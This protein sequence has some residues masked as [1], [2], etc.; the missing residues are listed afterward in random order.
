MDLINDLRKMNFTESE[1]KVYT[2]LLRYGSS[3]G[4]E[5]SKY[6]GVARSKIYNHIENLLA[7][8]VLEASNDGKTSYYK[9]ISP[10][11]LVQL[12][13]KSVNDTLKS[14]EYLA[15]NIPSQ[16]QEEAIWQVQDYDRMILK[17]VDIIESAQESIHIQIWKEDLAPEL[18]AALNRK[19]QEL[20]KSLVILYDRDQDYDCQL[21]KF[22]PHGFEMERLEDM[23]H[24]WV[25]LVA[26]GDNFLYAG[27]LFNNEVAGIYTRSKILG[28]FAREYV[29][30]DA[31]CLKLIDKFRPQLV[32]E[33][34]PTMDGIRDIY[35]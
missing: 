9:A 30:H 31:Y 12:T 19:T 2:T 32:E 7:R 35:S 23:S 25:T 33:Y 29:Q 17:L 14:F 27:I 24:R 13:R 16:D 26:D 4:Y 10:E 1:A 11:E 6:S 8:G 22:Y 15:S 34:G 20:E 21:E 5:I 3:T 18:I 28:F